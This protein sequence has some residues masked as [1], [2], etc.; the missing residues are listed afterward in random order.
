M[1]EQYAVLSEFY[2]RLMEEPV[3]AGYRGKIAHITGEG[4]VFAV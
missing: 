1:T 4:Q 3:A 2:D